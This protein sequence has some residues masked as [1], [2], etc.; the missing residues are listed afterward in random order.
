MTE[1]LHE[2]G[3][4]IVFAIA[5]I[6]SGVAIVTSM[7]L[8]PQINPILLHPEAYGNDPYVYYA[9]GERLNAGHDLYSIS[10]GDRLVGG[11]PEAARTPLVAPPMIAVVWRPLALLPLEVATRLWWAAGIAVCGLVVAWLW[12]RSGLIGLVIFF[13]LAPELA[14]TTL[15]GNVNAYV[16]PLLVLVWLTAIR[17][18]L[19]AGVSVALAT[20]FRISPIVLG[21]WLAV[22]A[23][24][25]A[26]LGVVAGAVFVFG[27]SLL[28]AGWANHLAWLDQARYF[29]S[30]GTTQPSF[31]SMLA[32]I[33][34]PEP[35]VV[36]SG[37]LLLAAAATIIVAMRARPSIGWVVGSLAIVLV[38]P[39]QHPGMGALAAAAVL[40]FDARRPTGES[41]G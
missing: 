32:G 35:L 33:G 5:R 20:A 8:L 23:S 6:L 2:T 3:G 21:A 19:L 36:A 22:T 31:Q 25:R 7:I 18:P 1:L 30:I 37:P 40:P 13:M 12:A 38:L 16:L 29:A 41:A 27:V 39:I 15:S 9:A 26:V 10:P 11:Q 4:R 28:G 14:W 34:L 24:R 17:R